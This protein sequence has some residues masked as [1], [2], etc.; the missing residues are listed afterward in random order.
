MNA[1]DAEA[2]QEALF[3]KAKINAANSKYAPQADNSASAFSSRPG[4]GFQ[5]SS[6]F[7]TVM[8]IKNLPP[9]HWK[10][11]DLYARL[12]VPTNCTTDKNKKQ[13]GKLALLYPRDKGGGGGEKCGG[14]TVGERFEAV[15]HAY[16]TLTNKF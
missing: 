5:P 12:G 14:G 10:Y 3:E 8:D 11:I 4:S 2:E 7:S 9:D 16:E 1:K 13:Y 15:K 6:A